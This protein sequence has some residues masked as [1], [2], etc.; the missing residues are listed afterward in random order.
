MEKEKAIRR[1][2]DRKFVSIDEEN[3]E[4]L[5]I[6][7]PCSELTP[8]KLFDRRWAMTVLAEAIRRLQEEYER[9]GMTDLFTAMQPY[10]TGEGESSF[11]EL[12]ARLQRNEGTAR[13]LVFRFRE[14]FRQLIRAVIADTVSDLEQVENELGHLQETLRES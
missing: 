5:Y 12:G 3:V 6:H 8:E 10:L 4:G 1:G 13:V 14:R 2:G 7:E 11:A 9:A